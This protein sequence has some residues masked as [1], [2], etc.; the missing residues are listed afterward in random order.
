MAQVKSACAKLACRC[1]KRPARLC[2]LSP[3]TPGEAAR[4]QRVLS[5]AGI[6]PPLI[7]YPGGPSHGYFRFAISSEHSRPQ[8]DALLNVLCRYAKA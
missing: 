8:L 3:S 6:Y 4:L 1:P 2:S 5:A 7:K